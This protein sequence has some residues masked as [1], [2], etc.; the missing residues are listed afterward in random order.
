MPIGQNDERITVTQARLGASLSANPRPSLQTT[1]YQTQNPERPHERCPAHHVGV[2]LNR[3]YASLA[4]QYG[5]LLN[6]SR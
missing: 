6:G 5:P 3:R 2:T 4:T 1:S